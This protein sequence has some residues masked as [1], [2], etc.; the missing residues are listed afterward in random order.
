MKQVNFKEELRELE[1]HL[2]KTKPSC[3]SLAYE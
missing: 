3:I 2:K 1:Q